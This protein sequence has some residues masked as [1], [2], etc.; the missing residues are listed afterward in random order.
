LCRTSLPEQPDGAQKQRRR[1]HAGAED[2]PFAR[3]DL[4][5]IFR[6]T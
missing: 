1:P 5:V 4:K 6:E 3:R 2:D